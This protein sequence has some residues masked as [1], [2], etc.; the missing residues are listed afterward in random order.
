MSFSLGGLIELVLLVEPEQ[1]FEFVRG[2]SFKILDFLRA[3]ISKSAL[4]TVG[5]P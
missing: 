2:L 3:E 5:S 1:M 4:M